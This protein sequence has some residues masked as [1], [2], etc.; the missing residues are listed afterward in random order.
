M[1]AAAH[2]FQA[3]ATNANAIS[4]TIAGPKP[5]VLAHVAAWPLLLLI[6]CVSLCG[7]MHLRWV[8]VYLWTFLCAIFADGRNNWNA[9]NEVNGN[10]YMSEYCFV[11]ACSRFYRIYMRPTKTTNN[12]IR[13]STNNACN[14]RI[15][16][17]RRVKRRHIGVIKFRIDC[18]CVCVCIRVSVCD[19]HLICVQTIHADTYHIGLVER[20]S[21]IM[22]GVGW[23]R[24][25]GLTSDFI[26]SRKSMR[27]E[28]RIWIPTIQSLCTS[29]ATHS[30]WFIYSMKMSASSVLRTFS[31]HRFSFYSYLKSGHITIMPENGNDL[32]CQLAREITLY[33][34][35]DASAGVNVCCCIGQRGNNGRC[36]SVH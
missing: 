6:E 10:I 21:G 7:A 33:L 16:A 28:W 23:L 24:T 5:N 32:Y 36:F 30:L 3:S 34:I 27:A 11:D 8:R 22:A 4:T 13:N 25:A 1:T 29:M 18:V 26:E 2:V 14:I 19:W 12:R 20:I 35:A 15:L 17:E 9:S 31:G